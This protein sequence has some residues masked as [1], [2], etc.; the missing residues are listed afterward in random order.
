M[1]AF[2]TTIISRRVALLDRNRPQKQDL[3]FS[4]CKKK[5]QIIDLALFQN[6]GWTKGIE[7]STTGVTI[8]CSTN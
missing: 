4:R 8:P 7:P 3:A 6:M 5:R 2:L 1:L